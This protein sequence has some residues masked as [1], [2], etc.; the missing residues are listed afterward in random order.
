MD[1][2]ILMG[3]VVI[4]VKCL[5]VPALNLTCSLIFLLTVNLTFRE[6]VTV[7]VKYS[8][9][10]SRTEYKV[11]FEHCNSSPSGYDFV[12]LSEKHVPREMYEACII[13]FIHP[14]KKKNNLNLD[15][16]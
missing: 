9:G 13:Q 16:R 11:P 7:N 10:Y 5:N 4:N 15:S 8:S 6:N 12:G 2:N 14:L 1:F 3:W